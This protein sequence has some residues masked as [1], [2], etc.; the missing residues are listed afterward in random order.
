MWGPRSSKPLK[1]LRQVFRKKA[2]SWDWKDT[3]VTLK[4][5]KKAKPGA[6]EGMFYFLYEAL[7]GLE[8]PVCGKL[9][10]IVETIEGEP[11][12][13]KCSKGRLKA[14]GTCIY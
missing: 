12:C 5:S 6:P 10:A 8:C 14:H 4:S 13:P 11:P 1:L 2:K 7:N 9:D 3:G